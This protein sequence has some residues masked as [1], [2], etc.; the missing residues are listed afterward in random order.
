MLT[1][2]YTIPIL[3]PIQS[4]SPSPP[5]SLGTLFVAIRQHLDWSL[6]GAFTGHHGYNQL[7]TRPLAVSSSV[8]QSHMSYFHADMNYFLNSNTSPRSVWSEVVVLFRAAVLW[9]RLPSNEVTAP[10]PGT[11]HLLNLQFTIEHLNTL[12]LPIALEW[13][14]FVC[15]SSLMVW[16]VSV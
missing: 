15:C 7:L 10:S 5:S 16:C 1:P 8:M 6:G 2:A 4:Q 12:F 9:L 3:L 14:L 11:F 13:S